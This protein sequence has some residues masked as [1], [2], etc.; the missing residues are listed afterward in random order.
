MSLDAFFSNAD[1]APNWVFL[2]DGNGN[3]TDSGQRI[4]NASTKSVELGD[5]NG[6]G[7][8]D[9]VAANSTEGHEIW[10]NNSSGVFRFGAGFGDGGEHV[11]LGDLD[12]DGDLDAVSA[13]VGANSVWLNDGHGRFSRSH[14]LQDGVT[15]HVVLGD[16]DGDGDL[17][18]VAANWR[19]EPSRLWFND[20]KASFVDSG[21]RLE[22]K[23]RSE[24]FA[25]GDLDG[26][27]DLDLATAISHEPDRIYFNQLA[28]EDPQP[29]LLIAG[30]IDRDGVVA[31]ADFLIMSAHFGSEHA[32]LSH[33]DLDLDGRVSHFATS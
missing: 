26:D 20:G 19:D 32:T 12:A 21:Q 11:A 13:D 7:N 6:D 10:I 24:H 29:D 9:A 5:V 30:D 2:N 31:L 15:S 3:F 16:L 17:D 4:G 14:E 28:K 27:G 25:L 33:G 18:V 22:P 23:S 8:L 1:D